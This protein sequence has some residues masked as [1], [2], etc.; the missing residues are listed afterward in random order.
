MYVCSPY[1]GS[2]LVEEATAISD[3]SSERKTSR[4]DGMQSDY[5]TAWKRDCTAVYRDCMAA[6]IDDTATLLTA[7]RIVLIWAKVRNHPEAPCAA[8]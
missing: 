8:G 5:A 3:C 2:W 6:C 1:F 4:Y 7:L